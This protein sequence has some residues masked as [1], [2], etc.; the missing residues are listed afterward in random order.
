MPLDIN[1]L[2]GE[3]AG[4]WIAHLAIP[5]G[6]A[7]LVRNIGRM[8]SFTKVLIFLGLCTL[9]SFICQFGFLAILQSGSCEG[10][11]D[12]SKIF[13]GAMVAATITAGMIAIP[14]FVEPMRLVVSNLF[15]SHKALL[16]PELAR[17]NDILVK[18]GDDVLKASFVEPPLQKGGAAISPEEYDAQTFQEIAVGASYWAAFAGAYGIGIGSLTAATCSATN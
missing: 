8:D 4:S 3:M 10:I 17:I 13:I 6:T 12:Y 15:I 11:K 7:M 5:F 2:Y 16:T 18:A 9:F 14:T 1:L